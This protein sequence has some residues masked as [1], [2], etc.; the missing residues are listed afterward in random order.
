M[1]P[2]Y[3][4]YGTGWP[5]ERE[6]ERC[7]YV[8]ALYLFV[9]L[10][11][12]LESGEKD[13]HVFFFL[14]LISPGLTPCDDDLC[15]FT[16]FNMF[17]LFVVL[18]WVLKA[19]CFFFRLSSLARVAFGWNNNNNKIDDH[20]II[21]AVY[22]CVCNTCMLQSWLCGCCI[23]FYGRVACEEEELS[24]S[25]SSERARQWNQ[26]LKLFG[27]LQIMSH[28]CTFTIGLRNFLVRFRWKCPVSELCW[29]GIMNIKCTCAS[30]WHCST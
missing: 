17:F 25:L 5:S 8:C 29:F 19:M 24:R 28:S 14:T 26:C 18:G 7:V 20:K 15:K 4:W 13:K 6:T 1:E 21:K 23:F 22:R 27:I 16:M 9:Y 3:I 11:A 12:C 10:F 30:C 2:V